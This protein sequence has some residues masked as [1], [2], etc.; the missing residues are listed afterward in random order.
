MKV[1]NC[2]EI[3]G[4]KVFGIKRRLADREFKLEDGGVNVEK[5]CLKLDS[6][7]S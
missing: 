1:A 7:M 6:S 3:C 4:L 5:K 2:L